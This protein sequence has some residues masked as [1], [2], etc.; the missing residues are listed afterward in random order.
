MAPK[1]KRSAVAP[2]EAPVS[3]R[4]LRSGGQLP[5]S[6]PPSATKRAVAS[7]RVTSPQK[8]AAGGKKL[9]LIVPEEVIGGSEEDLDIDTDGRDQARLPASPLETR[10]LSDE[11]NTVRVSSSTIAKDVAPMELDTPK[12][13]PGRPRVKARSGQSKGGSLV[14]SSLTIPQLS[15]NPPPCL[16]KPTPFAFRLL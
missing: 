10:Y 8:R 7:R 4:Q 3:K 12:R 6:P 15:R 2:E 1:R 5:A 9:D 11:T 16:A 13:K 14:A